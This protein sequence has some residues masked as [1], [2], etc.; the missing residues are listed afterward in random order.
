VKKKRGEAYG[1]KETIKCCEGR[2]QAAFTRVSCSAYF[3]DPEDGGDMLL[4]NVG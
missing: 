1:D 3:F 2:W 4:R